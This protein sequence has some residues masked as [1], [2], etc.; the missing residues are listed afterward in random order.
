[1]AA[2]QQGILLLFS[3]FQDHAG[4]DLKLNKRELKNLLTKEFGRVGDDKTAEVFNGLDEDESGS[5]DFEEF[6]Y[7]VAALAEASDRKT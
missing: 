4:K 6:I 5:V 7:M 1:M 3:A 2:L